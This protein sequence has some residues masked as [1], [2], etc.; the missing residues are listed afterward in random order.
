LIHGGESFDSHFPQSDLLL[1][2][3]PTMRWFSLGGTGVNL[4]N[5]SCVNL[6]EK[7][8][9]HGGLGLKNSVSGMTYELCLNGS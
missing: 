4:Q 7:I 2:H 8:I 3:I 1:L 5:H 6:N 9:M